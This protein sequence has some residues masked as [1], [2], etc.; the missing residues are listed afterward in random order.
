M[1]EHSTTFDTVSERV[2][3]AAERVEKQGRIVRGRWRALSLSVERLEEY[4]RALAVLR[5]A[6]DEEGRQ[7]GDMPVR[8]SV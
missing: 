8:A 4:E 6:A 2:R 3:E 5:T 7:A 1:G